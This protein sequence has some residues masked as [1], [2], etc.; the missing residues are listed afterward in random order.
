MSTLGWIR[1]WLVFFVLALVASGITAF[2]LEWELRLLADLLHATP[3]P[4]LVPGLVEW[5]ER[6]RDAIIATNADYP[7]LAY[8]TD[9]L[10]FAHLVIAVFFVGALIDPVRNVWVIVSGMIA[11]AGVIPLALIAGAVRG[12]PLGWQLVDMSFGVFGVV[13]LLIVLRL[14]R[15]RARELA[16]G[17]AAA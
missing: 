8:G 7:Y 11:C 16:S 4:D 10:A 2:P 1:A 6:V 3:A 9:W 13:P 15:R 17:D 12:I 5:V 14:I